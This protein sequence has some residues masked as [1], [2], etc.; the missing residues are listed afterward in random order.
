MLNN[1]L[2]IESLSTSLEKH[3][4]TPGFLL[5]LVIDSFMVGT[6]VCLFQ[7][8]RVYQLARAPPKGD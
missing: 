1:N 6:L 7:L 3:K 8:E 2:L 5:A 4:S